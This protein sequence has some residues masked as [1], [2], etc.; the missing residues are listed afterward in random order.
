MS[1]FFFEAFIIFSFLLSILCF[2][3]LILVVKILRFNL[4]SSSFILLTLQSSP[5]PLLMACSL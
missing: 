3:F 5:D 1:I 4:S 2:P